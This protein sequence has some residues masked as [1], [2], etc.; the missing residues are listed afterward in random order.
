MTTT[1]EVHALEREPFVLDAA[2]ALRLR[3]SAPLLLAPGAIGRM[4]SL[5][6]TPRA[7]APVTVHEPPTPQGN[8]VGVVDI[9][10]P[11]EQRASRH[12]CGYSD[13]YDAI[14]AR[15]AA[16]LED[17]RVG[18]V[19]MRIDSPGGDAAGC[20]EA[21]RRMRE[22]AK[23]SGK[24]VYAYADELAA[25]AAY[26]LS[27]VAEKMYLPPS[28][29]V[30]SIGVISVHGDESKRLENAG[31][32]LTVIKSGARKAE[33]N[34]L[35]PLT[36]VAKEH[37]QGLVDDLAGQFAELVTQAR[38]K[39]PKDWLKL[40]GAVAHGAD[41]VTKGLA[42]GVASFE[43]VISMAAE[44]AQRKAENMSIKEVNAAL[45]LPEG[46]PQTDTIES[47]KLAASARDALKAAT[48]KDTV[49]GAIGA[50]DAWKEKVAKAEAYETRAKAEEVAQK[51]A[52]M[53]AMVD[54]AVE[55]GR[56]PPAKRDA[57][58]AKAE[59]MGADWLDSHLELLTPVIT[60]GAVKRAAPAQR[61]GDAHDPEL[62][63]AARLA[64]MSVK[65]YLEWAPK[66]EAHFRGGDQ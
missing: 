10:G 48:G 63:A 32:G 54:A 45:G 17:E 20:F 25:S 2:M 28:G 14:A 18:S 23:E 61:S 44:A 34:S 46:A 49:G 53:V 40:E 4:F 9:M 38:G 60:M 24:P 22:A 66:A 26:A 8:M 59:R 41:A 56:I 57:T 29:A 33:F 15:F 37:M 43:E 50:L 7:A 16:A 52:R 6:G 36:D 11:L 19:V 51:A 62:R 30:G 5:A 58:L 55:D 12:L 39:T 3:G 1:I 65:D 35:Q 64:G 47:A 27:T 31:V 42:D 13:G 21:V